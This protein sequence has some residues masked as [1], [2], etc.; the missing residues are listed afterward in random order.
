MERPLLVESGIH[1]FNSLGKSTRNR[2][3]GEGAENGDWRDLSGWLGAKGF[4]YNGCI[5]DQSMMLNGMLNGILNGGERG[6]EPV[7]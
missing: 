5:G 3:S 6:Y 1:Y 4:A 7:I 2:V